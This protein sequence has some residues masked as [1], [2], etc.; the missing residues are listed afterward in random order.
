MSRTAKLGAAAFLAKLMKEK[1]L[2][3]TYAEFECLSCGNIIWS[4][5]NDEIKDLVELYDGNLLEC[6]IC[7]GHEFNVKIKGK[8]GG[9]NS[10]LP[11][12]LYR[13]RRPSPQQEVKSGTQ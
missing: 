4:D 2:T 3:R 6:P 9:R 1:P 5:D 7:G 12:D 8:G 10:F 11:P 13:P